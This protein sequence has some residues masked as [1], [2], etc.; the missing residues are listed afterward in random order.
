MMLLVKWF[1]WKFL[2]EMG[3]GNAR[4]GQNVWIF[5]WNIGEI[6]DISGGVEKKIDCI[7]NLQKMTQISFLYNFKFKQCKW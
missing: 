7:K 6:L 4:H 2:N 3:W 1:D 5:Y